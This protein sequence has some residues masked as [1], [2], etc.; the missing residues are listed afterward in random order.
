MAEPDAFDMEYGSSYAQ[1]DGSDVLRFVQRAAFVD[2][3][4]PFAESVAVRAEARKVVD[5][6]CAQQ[7]MQ[8]MRQ[9][10]RAI[11]ACISHQ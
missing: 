10:A 3:D 6:L 2:V 7:G 11:K 8:E 5:M 1:G 9:P 4:G